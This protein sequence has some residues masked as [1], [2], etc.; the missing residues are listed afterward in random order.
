MKQ[1]KGFVLNTN[2]SRLRNFL[3]ALLSLALAFTGLSASPALAVVTYAP[4]DN[5][6]DQDN[7]LTSVLPDTNKFT[8]PAGATSAVVDFSYMLGTDWVTANRGKI[9]SLEVAVT[10][11]N[12]QSLSAN[13][14]D[15]ATL[16]FSSMPSLE[17]C[18]TFDY[19][20]CT[21]SQ[22][23]YNGSPITLTIGSDKTR[24]YISTTVSIS[25]GYDINTGRGI[26]P[27]AGEYTVVATIK[28][29]GNTVPV[30]GITGS[31]TK[32][33][34]SLVHIAMPGD[35]YTPSYTLNTVGHSLVMCIDPTKIAVGD[36]LTSK[37]FI[38]DV[39]YTSM[40]LQ[41]DWEYRTYANGGMGRTYDA[42]G[43]ATVT[44]DDLTNGLLSYLD[45]YSDTMNMTI[46][47]SYTVKSQ[48]LDQTG[49]DVSANCAPSVPGKPTLSAPG[50]GTVSGSFALSTGADMYE[51][52]W[53]LSTDL[54]TPA[55]TTMA[56]PGMMMNGW[57]CSLSNAIVGKTYLLKVRAAFRDKYS[58]FSTI[59]DSITVQAAGFV[60]SPAIS[61]LTTA[62]KASLVSNSID[63]ETTADGVVS[64]NDGKGGTL[65]LYSYGTRMNC[66][67][68]CFMPNGTFKLKRATA[69]GLDSSFA[70][71]GSVSWDPAIDGVMWATQGWYGTSAD[72][73]TITGSGSSMLAG[74][75]LEIIQGSNSSATTTITTV[76]KAPFEAACGTIGTGFNLK[77]SQWNSG[78]S[79][80]V[81]PISGPSAK[82]L[83]MLQCWKEYTDT[84]S[85]KF[86]PATSVLIT[87]D[88]ATH[89]NVIKVFGED[90]A[91]VN[92]TNV[93]ATANPAATGSAVAV[94]FFVTKQ[95]VTSITNG[96][97]SQTT[98]GTVAKREI[99]RMTADGNFSTTSDAWP[100]AGT[101]ISD[102]PTLTI[103]YVNDGSFYALYRVG[104]TTSLF[105]VT[106]SGAASTPVEIVNDK[107]SDLPNAFYMIPFGVQSGSAS[108]ISLLVRSGTV[109]T[110]F[111]I[112]SVKT[113][114]AAGKTGEI[115]NYT[116]SAGNGMMNSSIVN[117]AS[118]DVIWWH[119]NAA[120]DGKFTLYKWRDPLYVEPVALVPTVSNQVSGKG[121]NT[122]A[123]GTKLTITGTNLGEVT[124]VKF[125]TVTATIGTRSATSLEVTVPSGTTGTATITLVH[126]GGNVTAGSYKYLGASKL[127]QTVT[128]NAGANTAVVGATARTLSATVAI[129]GET[130]T[131]SLTYSS[132]TPAIC[133]VSG[134]TLTFVA[135][136]S[137]VVK[138]VQAASA[139]AAE[140]TTTATITVAGK[141]QTVTVTAPTTAQKIIGTSFQ[142]VASSSTGLA[143][144]YASNN[145]ANC[146]VSATGLV[147]NLVA[148]TC[149]ITVTQAGTATWAAASAQANYTVTKKAQTVT[150]ATPSAGEKLASVEGIFLYGSS[151][152]GGALTYSFSTPTV[153]NKGTFVANHVLNIKAGTCTIVISQAGDA[154][155]A[156]ASTTL[157]YTVG[158]AGTTAIVDAGNVGSPVAL[159]NN[160]TKVNVLSEV[161]YWN[162]SLGELNVRSRG[163]WVGPIT[164]TATFKIG[165]TD[166]TCKVSYG[167]LKGVTDS[168]ANQVKGFS[169]PN[170]CAGTTTTDKAALAAL[171]KLTSPI[172]VKIVVVRD[173]RNP[174]NY[175]LKGQNTTRTIY[176][177][178][179]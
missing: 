160:G 90:S 64:V 72:K 156:P 53:Y 60:V 140:G 141:A 6:V 48:V 102:A 59:S 170:M 155:W 117:T 176:V 157:T 31:V 130:A 161:V 77:S 115:I 106:S 54:T 143:L 121:L 61:G 73:W 78:G 127:A 104:T 111:A 107:A 112:V 135:K 17:F 109:S 179:G 154:T 34:D 22:P 84:N 62:G 110:K 136:G 52:A 120:A 148:T 128:L 75:Q 93:L 18:A 171:K 19:S 167:V 88:D 139:W 100:N 158:A 44:S 65:Q 125:G 27:T 97:M 108:D 113:A 174:A 67:P 58:A 144:T 142:L 159:L 133:S 63:N 145:P 51:C 86:Y 70:G 76:G 50:S 57:T 91:E 96:M 25:G 36:T 11:P 89:V 126:A 41:R 123:A 151:T 14:A 69:T 175:T 1:P 9:M 153:C 173:L 137:C 3:V 23:S 95:K 166:Y 134:T 7:L 30:D 94:T 2:A 37:L 178:I 132:N 83:Y 40:G 150:V 92:A 101:S 131:P 56:T 55:K 82:Q 10:G 169:A 32:N 80:S 146:T 103:P 4:A 122:P 29:S 5:I 43:Q 74:P 105:K 13:P 114:T 129:T 38:N 24:G 39:E 12:G 35:T 8:V 42:S 164:A 16:G 162:K 81:Y 165:T 152:S 138:A 66:P 21:V 46:G 119:S 99:V 68:N 118:K 15:P 87:I 172:T 71:T 168:T 79:I 26:L 47:T 149:V 85:Q 28:A 45:V 116:Y 177:T 20:S 49:E 163:V 124:A 33:R 147:K 98:L